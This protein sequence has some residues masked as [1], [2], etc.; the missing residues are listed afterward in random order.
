VQS[1]HGHSINGFVGGR[2]DA[3][4]N[5]L[6]GFFRSINYAPQFYHVPHTMPDVRELRIPKT[7]LEP[8]GND[9]FNYDPQS[10]QWGH[11]IKKELPAG[12]L[13]WTGN[14]SR[15]TKTAISGSCIRVWTRERGRTAFWN[16]RYHS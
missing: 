13:T 5:D 1:P 2:D 9:L 4:F 11:G 6:P 12:P 7:F 8:E 3:F 14:P 15:R 16:Y 10:P